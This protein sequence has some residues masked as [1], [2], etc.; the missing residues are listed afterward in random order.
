MLNLS[1]NQHNFTPLHVSC[2]LAWCPTILVPNYPKHLVVA[3]PAFMGVLQLCTWE[4][5]FSAAPD[6]WLSTVLSQ[7]VV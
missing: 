3:L 6:H 1:S 2:T 4:L 7:K 5:G